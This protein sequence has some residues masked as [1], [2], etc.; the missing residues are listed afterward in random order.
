MS[1]TASEKEETDAN[2]G[3]HFMS[4]FAPVAINQAVELHSLAKMTEHFI[5]PTLYIILDISNII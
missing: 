3:I 1:C 4:G 5:C 2:D